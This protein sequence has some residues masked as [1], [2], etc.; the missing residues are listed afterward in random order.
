MTITLL[1][2]DINPKEQVATQNIQGAILSII[3]Q[4]IFST[5]YGV[6]FIYPLLM[7]ILRR[8][9]GENIYQFSAFYT[10]KLLMEVPRL[11]IICSLSLGIPYYF[12]K[13]S[14][15]IWVFFQMLS[16]LTVAAI[17]SNSYGFMLSGFFKGMM[18]E[19]AAPFDI[20][21]LAFSGFYLNL[22]DY[23]IAK[24]ISPFFFTTEAVSIMYWHDIDGIGKKIT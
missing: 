13:L 19:A 18:T 22:R 15:G 12:T 14:K 1:F 16:V 23:P 9:T 21:F 24:H 17:T 11:L 4:V 10:A 2:Y 3:S 8:E 6:M 5:A 20:L 7:P